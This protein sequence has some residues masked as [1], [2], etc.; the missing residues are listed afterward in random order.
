[1][2]V[3]TVDELIAELKKVSRESLKG[4]AIDDFEGN[5]GWLFR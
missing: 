2:Q 3:F 4:D 5:I 1:M